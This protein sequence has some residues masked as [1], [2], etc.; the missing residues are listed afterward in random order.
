[1]VRKQI[2]VEESHDRLLK[3]QAD[4]TGL[5][6]SELIRQ[7]IVS[8]YDPDAARLAREIS[9]D[10]LDAAFDRLAAGVSATSGPLGHVDRSEGTDR[11]G[12]VR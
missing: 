6:E 8:A 9:A 5:T 2:Y 12:R 10:R 3:E 11:H 1:M 4:L 7:A